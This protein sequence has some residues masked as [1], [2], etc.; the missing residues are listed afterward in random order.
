V[1]GG[2]TAVTKSRYGLGA[3]RLDRERSRA[4]L[5]DAT[6]RSSSCRNLVRF[7]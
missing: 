5:S 1:F 3:L 2:Q 7:A 6:E 4:N